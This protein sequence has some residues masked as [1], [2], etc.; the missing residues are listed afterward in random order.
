MSVMLAAA[1]L[2][3]GSAHA[4]VADQELARQL[5]GFPEGR[6]CAWL[7]TSGTPPTGP[8]GRSSAPTGAPSTRSCTAATGSRG[9][10]EAARR[11]A[12]LAIV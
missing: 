12:W 1:D 8:S 10:G 3:I 9:Y 6:F 2:G 7:I 4:A 11:Q 5:L